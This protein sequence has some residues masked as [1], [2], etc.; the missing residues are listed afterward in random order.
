MEVFLLG[1][2]YKY[3]V[4]QMLLTLYPEE[5]PEYPE[6]KPD[7]RCMVIK[8]SE[9]AKFMTASCKSVMDGK[10]SYGRAAALKSRLTSRL[11]TDRV[12]Q[13]LVKDA[14]YRAALAGGLEHPAW[15]SLSGVRPGKVFRPLLYEGHSPEEATKIFIEKYDVTEKRAKLC[16]DT[17]IETVKAE[18][19]LDAIIAELRQYLANNYKDQAHAMREK[20]HTRA[21]ELHSA[22]KLSEEL[23][24]SYEKQYQSFTE[25]MKNYN[26]R[27]FYH[28]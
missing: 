18:K 23:F 11:M 25:Q 3:A 2:D 22:G 21:E 15:G 26:H 1:H 6:G 14:I 20:L 4:E 24:A 19:E 9:G 12:C 5:R 7:G 8:L 10:T 16:R 13:S 27:E 17:S 28:S